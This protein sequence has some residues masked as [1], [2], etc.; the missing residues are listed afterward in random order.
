MIP[1]IPMIPMKAISTLA[2]AVV[3]ATFVAPCVA[4]TVIDTK[5]IISTGLVYP[6]CIT[7]APGDST[8][9]FV[10][11]KAGRIRI[12]NLATNALVAT[13]FLDIDALV[14]GGASTGDEQG[15]LGMAFD[16]NYATNGQFYVYYTGTGTNNLARYTVSSNPNVA[17]SAGVVMMTWAD[18]YTNHNGGWIEF[19]P[20]GNL[21]MGTGD[22]GSANDPG[23]RAQNLSE[24]LGKLHRIKPSTG[25]VAPYYT[26]PSDNPFVG[27]AT[28]ADDTVWSSGMRNPWRCSFDRATGDLWIADVGQNAVEEINFQAAGTGAGRNYGWRCTEGGSSTGLTG[29]TF[30]SP[31]LTPAI[32]VYSHVAGT[33]GGYSISGG[34]VYRGCRIPDLRGTYFFADYVNANIW[35][36]RYVNGVKSEF[37]NRNAALGTSVEGGVVNQVVTFGEDEDGEVYIADHG[38]QIYK[39]IPASG[40]GPCIPPLVGDLD[41][42]GAV[43][44]ADLGL[45]LAGWGTCG[46]P[47]PGDLDRNGFVEGFDLG[48]LLSNWSI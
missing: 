15:L 29:C 47:C 11:E 33:T 21:Y 19:G 37:Q 3:A 40:D 42:N 38:G 10:L 44:G 36:F 25:G 2:V 45:L 7:H 6:T 18:P 22:G 32:H 24:K 16:P 20:D 34:V 31:L 30:G 46:T 9:L 41:L 13:S 43:N 26:I 4:Q 48:L 28:T 14:T 17:N 1:M 39:I 5:R 27:G 35:S 12:I 8:R 23:N